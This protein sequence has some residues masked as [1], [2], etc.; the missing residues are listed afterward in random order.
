MTGVLH[1]SREGK[2]KTGDSTTSAVSRRNESG[3]KDSDGEHNK[4][5]DGGKKTEPPRH[6][7]GNASARLIAKDRLEVRVRQPDSKRTK[8]KR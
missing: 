1:R 3:L 7:G 8:K 6:E 2:S 4:T 5:S